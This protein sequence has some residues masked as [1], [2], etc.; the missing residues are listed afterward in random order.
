MDL[1]LRVPFFSSTFDVVYKMGN[2]VPDSKLKDLLEW[3]RLVCARAYCAHDV[4]L[5]YVANNS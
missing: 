3:R 1:D 4:R 2:F 5:P